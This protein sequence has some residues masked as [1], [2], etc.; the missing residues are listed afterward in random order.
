MRWVAE[1]G[2]GRGRGKGDFFGSFSI[3]LSLVALP[4]FLA[5]ALGNFLPV[6][7]LNAAGEGGRQAEKG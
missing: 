1:G 3:L 4:S 5:A 7:S 6:V 2:A